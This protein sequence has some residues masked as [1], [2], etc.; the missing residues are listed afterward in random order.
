MPYVSTCLVSGPIGE[1]VFKRYW[2]KNF[3][4]SYHSL[5]II[6]NLN[7]YVIKKPAMSFLRKM[8]EKFH[9]GH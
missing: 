2:Q 1:K 8:S 3:L 6:D 9:L 7:T 4:S 5:L